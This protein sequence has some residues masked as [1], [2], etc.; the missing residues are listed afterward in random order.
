MADIPAGIK[1]IGNGT[2]F[3]PCDADIVVTEK[4]KGA[5]NNSIQL[6]YLPN[7]SGGTWTLSLT[8]LDNPEQSFTFN[9]NAT[10]TDIYEQLSTLTGAD[11]VSVIGTGKALDPF[12]IEFIGQLAG[13][14]ISPMVADGSLLTGAPY[15]AVE[16]ITTGTKN[17]RQTITMSDNNLEPL[18]IKFGGTVNPQYTIPIEYNASLNQR[19][20][21]IQA[22]SNVGAN[23]VLVTGGTTDR[24][25]AYTGTI[26]IDFVGSFAGQNVAQVELFKSNQST[27]ASAYV[28]VTD[29]QGGE[30]V[31]DKQL[32]KL[33]AGA[34]TFTLTVY[35]PN[36]DTIT[37]TTGQIAYNATAVALK[38]AILEVATFLTSTDLTVESIVDASNPTLIAWRLEFGGQYSGLPTKQMTID[39]SSLEGGS[40]IIDQA[41]IGASVSERQL[42]TITKA[43]AGYYRLSVTYKG[44][45]RITERIR[46]KATAPSIA[47]S[48]Y[49]IPFLNSSVVRVFDQMSGVTDKDVT[50]RYM[51]V[52]SPLF[53]DVSDIVPIFRGTLLCNPIVMPFVPSGPY[54]YTPAT[55]G[56]SEDLS[57]QSGPLFT[58][59]GPGSE[60]IATVICPLPESANKATNIV[61][62]RDLVSP[63][64]KK[65]DANGN[66]TILTIRDIVLMKG[67]DPRLHTPYLRDFATNRLVETSYSRVLEIG[68]S[69]VVIAKPL[70]TSGNLNRISNHL[71]T[72][73]E[74]LPSRYVVAP[75]VK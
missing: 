25:V 51:I 62:Q 57:C 66:S 10:A 8:V 32:I 68:M 75:V 22:L 6:I 23:N 38:A 34:G 11:N 39:G 31:N 71:S 70:T 29:W 15:S 36:D 1:M 64:Q 35:K 7:P 54:P 52:F 5:L 63:A 58:R 65:T 59:P 37:A 47:L 3:L 40:I 18:V 53:G 17:E 55:I 4:Q 13:T 43:N 21:A 2:Y 56:E 19:Q 16:K 30:G 60:P 33:T 27:P 26:H 67:K 73:K 49:K 42:I 69:V 74:I 48:L 61:Y 28:V 14:D 24:D 45:T 50:Y 41:S 9:W 46:Y 44:E 72:S 20:A 12:T